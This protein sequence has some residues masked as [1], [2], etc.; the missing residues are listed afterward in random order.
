[1]IALDRLRDSA[2]MGFEVG[3]EASSIVAPLETKPDLAGPYKLLKPRVQCRNSVL[4]SDG[5]YSR[6]FPPSKYRL[7]WSG[8]R[9]NHDDRTDREGFD[10][11]IHDGDKAVGASASLPAGSRRL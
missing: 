10:V 4:G 6:I 5:F 8:A 7:C 2:G 9:K 3:S 1:V 11:F